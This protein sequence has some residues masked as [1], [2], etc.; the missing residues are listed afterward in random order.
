MINFKS[1]LPKVKIESLK[2]V[3][4]ASVFSDIK[5][6]LIVWLIQFVIS[7]IIISGG[8]YARS[9]WLVAV[10]VVTIISFLL[11]LE[12]GKPK[13]KKEKSRVAI[14]NF[15][16]FV[17]LD[18]VVI[19]FG[20]ESSNREFF[21]FYGTWIIYAIIAAY[22]FTNLKKDTVANIDMPKIGK[23][24]QDDLLTKDSYSL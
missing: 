20:L 9:V 12:K 3:R 23:S 22:P 21:N 5:L 18:L 17:I 6:P 14:T 10:Q 1:R 13:T 24:N 8:L 15:A 11:I 7:E 19:Y 16:V 2:K 4:E